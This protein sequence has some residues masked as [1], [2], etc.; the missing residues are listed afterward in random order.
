[1]IHCSTQLTR[2]NFITFCRAR[3]STSNISIYGLRY[4]PN[5]VSKMAQQSL[6]EASFNLHTKITQ[7]TQQSFVYDRSYKL[8]KIKY[9]QFD[10]IDAQYFE[11]N[12]EKGHQLTKFV[13]NKNIPHFI[14]E[15]VIPEL[16]KLEEIKELIPKNFSH[17]AWLNWKMM[18]NTYSSIE[19]NESIIANF[20]YHNDAS[21]GSI[22]AILTLLSE[23]SFELKATA[24][25]TKIF[26]FPLTAG[27]LILLSGDVRSKW[28]HRIVPKVS[29]ENQKST[30][31]DLHRISI[32]LSC[33]PIGLPKNFSA[34]AE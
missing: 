2:P 6:L 7:C 34:V 14:R 3:F 18:F 5:F 1:M 11:R 9:P 32:V 4:I 29:Q 22:L 25:S 17:I 12:G 31:L 8:L 30:S 27:S 21:N 16:K 28:L 24:Q 23:A 13:D 20:P 10:G 26:A 15:L 33:R 19:E